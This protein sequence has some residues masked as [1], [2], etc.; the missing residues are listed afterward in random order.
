M[1][2]KD[3]AALL[4]EWRERISGLNVAANPLKWHEAKGVKQCADEL[5]A[6]LASAE[7]L[8]MSSADLVRRQKALALLDRWIAEDRAAPVTE[9]ALD[10]WLLALDKPNPNRADLVRRLQ[11]EAANCQQPYLWISALLREA[12]DYIKRKG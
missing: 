2:G 9:E 10:A 8:N 5:E 11:E 7:Q 3:L 1:A 6:V 12:A 4:R